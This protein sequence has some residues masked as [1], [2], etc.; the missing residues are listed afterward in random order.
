M[1]PLWLTQ[2]SRKLPPMKINDYSGECGQLHNQPATID[3]RMSIAQMFLYQYCR[4]AD[5]IL[6][7]NGPLAH[8][9]SPGMRNTA[10]F[11]WLEVMKLKLRKLILRAVS[12]FSS[13]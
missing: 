10:G 2:Q 3:N 12:A 6:N 9:I 1:L 13:N 8:T 5:G 7:P 4:P 11:I